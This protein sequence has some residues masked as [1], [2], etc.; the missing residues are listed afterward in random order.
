MGEKDVNTTGQDQTNLAQTG[1][2]SCGRFL[3]GHEPYR[4]GG[5]PKRKPL[6]EEALK[7]LPL[8]E[9]ARLWV[10]KIRSGEGDALKHLEN[11]TDGLPAAKHD[12]TG[13]L[14]V[15]VEDESPDA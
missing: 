10:E 13:D 11:Q 7:Q 5:R 8:D 15:R 1:R 6:L 14:N 9:A 2:D 3:P 4:E 12:L